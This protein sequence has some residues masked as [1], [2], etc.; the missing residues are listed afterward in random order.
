MLHLQEY[1]QY[2]HCLHVSQII[3]HPHQNF[4]QNG[5]IFLCDYKRLDG[6]EPNTIN[7][8]EQYLMAP[9]ILLHKTPEDKLVPVAIQVRLANIAN[10]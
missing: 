4:K 1:M 9:V 7:G 6:L 5:N 2:P 10:S 3:S 8:K